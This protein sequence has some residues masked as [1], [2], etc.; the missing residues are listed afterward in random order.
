MREE[1][2]DNSTVQFVPDNQSAAILQELQQHSNS[3]DPVRVIWRNYF[4]TIKSQVIQTLK[5][6][7]ALAEFHGD[8]RIEF[9]ISK[10]GKVRDL[11]VFETRNVSNPGQK[12]LISEVLKKGAYAPLPGELGSEKKIRLTVRL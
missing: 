11:E 5:N 8:V 10:N 6:S 7:P 1:A 2:V 12:M 4:A 3:S 9:S